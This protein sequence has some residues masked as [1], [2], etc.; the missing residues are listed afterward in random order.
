MISNTQTAKTNQAPEPKVLPE[1]PVTEVLIEILKLEVGAEASSAPE[2]TLLIKKIAQISAGQNSSDAVKEILQNAESLGVPAAWLLFLE[3]LACANSGEP[4][5][6]IILF[7]L[8]LELKSDLKS[9]IV[10]KALMIALCDPYD[11][12][13]EELSNLVNRL[14]YLDPE[15]GQFLRSCISFKPLAHPAKKY[16]WISPPAQIVL[17]GRW[18]VSKSSAHQA[19]QSHLSSTLQ[20]MDAQIE[21]CV[22]S[23]RPKLDDSAAFEQSL[24]EISA[25]L[26]AGG[27][28]IAGENAAIT[29]NRGAELPS[30]LLR[31]TS[32]LCFTTLEE[33]YRVLSVDSV[34]ISRRLSWIPGFEGGGVHFSARALLAAK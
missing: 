13:E 10:G 18:Q 6:A 20:E 17:D 22:Y 24:I 25:F 30:E 32:S 9:A 11:G 26:V 16:L 21:I 12:A 4:G 2:H 29:A 27:L 14:S 19:T 3:A 7:D 34:E 23:C 8:A 28:V 15:L 33:H 31:D 1:I 5:K